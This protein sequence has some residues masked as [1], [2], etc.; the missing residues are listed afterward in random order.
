MVLLHVDILLVEDNPA[1]VELTL[2][3]LQQHNLAHN[4]FVAHD[5]QEAIDFLF[6]AGQYSERRDQPFPKLILLDLKLPKLNGI[7]VLHSLKSDGTAKMIPVVILTSSA[8]EKD[9][10]ECYKLGANSYVQKPLDY[11]KF[12]NVIGDIGIYWMLTNVT[13]VNIGNPSS[14]PQAENTVNRAVGRIKE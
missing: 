1:D 12:M 3:A 7:E 14:R 2:R 6:S 5:G 8:Q 4:V 10:D 13:P 11:E 9:I